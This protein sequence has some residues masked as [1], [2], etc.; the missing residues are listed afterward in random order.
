MKYYKKL[1]G[2]R[3]YL[4]PMNVEDAEIYVKWLN[5]FAVTDAIGTS[6][7]VV[8]LEG[9][10]EWLSQNSSQSQF[11]IIR[12]E[13]DKLI[14]NCGIQAIDQSRQ[15]AEVGLFIGD[16]ENRNKG[17]GQDVLNTL[18]NYGFN[19]LNLNNIMLKVFSF[20]EGAISCYKKVGFKEI[21]RRR[22]SYYLKG[23]FY[24]DVFMDILREEF[25]QLNK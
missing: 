18:L 12:A 10:R 24:D 17:Y 7:R 8:S 22:Q 23:K 1:V 2:E 6:N 16:E 5:D 9:E 13:D 14:G 15:C 11:A 25:H 20:N 3:I 19:Y 4:S 21:G